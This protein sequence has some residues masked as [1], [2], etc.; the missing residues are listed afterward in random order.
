[1]A[2]EG[3][4]KL[5]RKARENPWLQDAVQ[6]AVFFTM[7]L[8]AETEPHQ[9]RHSHGVVLVGRGQCLVAQNALADELKVGRQ[10][11]RR[12]FAN[13]KKGGLI[14]PQSNHQC[15]LVTICNFERYQS[16]TVYVQPAHQPADQP[17]PNHDPTILLESKNPEKGRKKDSIQRAQRLATGSDA[18]PDGVADKAPRGTRLPE[19]WVPSERNIADALKEGIP[20]DEVGR[21]GEEYRDHWIAQPGR[22]GVKVNWD[23]TWRNRC[24]S[25]APRYRQRQSTLFRQRKQDPVSGMWFDT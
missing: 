21:V 3:W 24:R 25:V 19:D 22:S 18:P 20:R 2:E 12:A 9:R 4:I 11:I 14:N 16:T 6:R 13:L 5:W 17:R 10:Q 23:A 7:L 8:D 15:T 1:V